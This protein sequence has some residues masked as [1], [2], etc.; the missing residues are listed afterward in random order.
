MKEWAKEFYHSKDWT[1]TRR[2]YLIAHH[3][4]CERCGEPAKVVH[5]KHYLTKRNI[6]NA[7]IALN[8]DNLEAL[9]QDCHNKE[10]HAAADTRRYKFDA[11]GNII[12]T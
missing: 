11:D 4:L 5:H 10:H 2:A 3:Y 12:Q 6:N 1:D 9:C 8:W 7:D